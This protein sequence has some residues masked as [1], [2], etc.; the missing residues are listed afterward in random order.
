MVHGV[1]CQACGVEAPARY[2]EFYQNVGAL[3]MRFHKRMKGNL[4]KRCIHKYFWK[5]TMTTATVGWWGTISLVVTPF[6]V[7]NNIVRYVGAL[8]LEGVP[9]GARPPVVDEPARAR[10]GPHKAELVRRLNAGEKL[11]PVAQEVARKAG[12]TP[13]QVVRYLAEGA[14][15]RP[16]PTFGF[17]VQP[18]SPAPVASIPLE[19]LPPLEEA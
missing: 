2:V 12:V 5:Y 10:L 13:G 19:P 14:S 18:A 11:V 9:A 6:F 16:P 17:P 3:V 7:V 15:R 4:C 1:I 8:G